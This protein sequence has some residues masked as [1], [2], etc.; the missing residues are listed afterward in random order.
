MEIIWFLKQRT[1]FIRYYYTTAAK[2]FREIIRKIEQEEEPFV[3]PYSEDGEPAFQEEWMEADRSLNVLGAMCVSMLSDSL[4]L[5]FT[6]W[7]RQLGVEC[8]KHRNKFK[9]NGFV[10]GY[11]ACFQDLF[12]DGWHSC[13][14]NINIIEQVVLARNSAQHPQ[15]I[16]RTGIFHNTDILKSHKQP[17]FLSDMEKRMLESREVNNYIWHSL[18]LVVTEDALFTAIIEIE[19]LCDWL[20]ERLFVLM[21]PPCE[22]DDNNQ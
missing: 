20:E 10:A 7:E 5:Y 2:P 1:H 15:E 8:E 22:K 16:T 13:P 3:P 6:T 11:K 19:I 12:Q 4:K 9:K 14:A 21:Y 18:S 17:L